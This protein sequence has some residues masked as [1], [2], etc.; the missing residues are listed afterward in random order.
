MG[1]VPILCIPIL[2]TGNFCTAQNQ[3]YLHGID[4]PT[5]FLDRE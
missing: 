5:I 4:I 2:L 1:P 3:K